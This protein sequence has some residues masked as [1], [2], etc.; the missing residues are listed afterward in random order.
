MR[1]EQRMWASLAVRIKM[2]DMRLTVPVL[3]K[4]AGVDETTIRALLA[5]S[6]WPRSET[7]DRITDALGWPVGELER[8]ASVRPDLL[9]FT[10]L[11]LLRELYRREQAAS[12]DAGT[13]GDTPQ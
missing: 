7:R 11:E 5:G 1:Q 4:M 9:A 2:N 6:R 12:P 3:A 10:T 13:S 8:R